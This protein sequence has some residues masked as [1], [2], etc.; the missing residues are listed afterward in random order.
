MKTLDQFLR[1]EKARYSSSL[2]ENVSFA[3]NSDSPHFILAIRLNASA[4]IRGCAEL[5]I[6]FNLSNAHA[7]GVYALAHC[8]REQRTTW[9]WNETSART[10]ATIECTKAKWERISSSVNCVRSKSRLAAATKSNRSDSFSFV[11][12][13][14]VFANGFIFLRT[15]NGLLHSWTGNDHIVSAQFSTR[16]ITC[17]RN[18]DAKRTKKKRNERKTFKW[19]LC[20]SKLAIKKE[21]NET[22]EKG[23]WEKWS[24]EWWK[25]G[26]EK[27]Q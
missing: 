1:R 13:K 11:H 26:R 17:L 21:T 7:F 20:S 19:L 6:N 15:T 27:C 18:D 16:R 25:R 22:K 14:S 9:P 24:E 4:S 5:N 12:E 10:R 8:C 23:A 3:H 2:H